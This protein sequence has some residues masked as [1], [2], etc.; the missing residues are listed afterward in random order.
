MSTMCLVR[1]HKTAFPS[2]PR[3]LCVLL[4][5]VRG[6]LAQLVCTA[7]NKHK[8]CFC[9]ALLL[10]RSQNGT[11]TAITGVET[12]CYVCVCLGGQATQMWGCD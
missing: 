1:L 11:G 5:T 4:E 3:S 12:T 8:W 2:L 10:S 9:S 7:H 6:L